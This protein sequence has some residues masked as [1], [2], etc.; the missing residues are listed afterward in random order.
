MAVLEQV[1]EKLYRLKWGR[2]D[3]L[4]ALIISPTRELAMQIFEELRKVG[5][6]HDLSA[7]LLIGGKN[8]KEEQD[9]VNGDSLGCASEVS[10]YMH[11]GVATIKTSAQGMSLQG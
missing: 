6:R 4:G 10:T 2:L 7:G 11:M 5:Q 9:R 8:V 3:G 1:L